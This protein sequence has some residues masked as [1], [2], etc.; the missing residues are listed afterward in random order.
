MVDAAGQISLICAIRVY[1]LNLVFVVAAFGI[2]NN[3]LSVG[4]PR[5]I[6]KAYRV[7]GQLFLIRAVRA[8]N[9]Q[10]HAAVAV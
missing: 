6:V 10:L 5:R 4:R 9:E 3:L 7:I 1:N 2:E 8:H